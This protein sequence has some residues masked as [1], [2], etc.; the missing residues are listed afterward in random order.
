MKLSLGHRSPRATGNAALRPANLVLE[1]KAAYG[2]PVAAGGSVRGGEEQAGNGGIESEVEGVGVGEGQGGGERLVVER[3]VAPIVSRCVFPSW[4][5]GGEG[6]G[7]GRL[8]VRK[9]GPLLP[10]PRS[11]ETRPQVCMYRYNEPYFRHK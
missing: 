9:T 7:G 6:R 3:A 4:P 11:Y 5:I 2:L 1:G 10:H 8:V